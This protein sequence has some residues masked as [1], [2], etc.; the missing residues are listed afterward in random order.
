MNS[1]NIIKEG[2]V[3][4]ANIVK[5]TVIN[6]IF[7]IAQSDAPIDIDKILDE[8]KRWILSKIREQIIFNDEHCHIKRI[9]RGNEQKI[10]ADDLLNK[11]PQSKTSLITGPSKSE[12]SKLAALTTVIWAMSAESRF[13]LVLFISPLF[14]MDKIPLHK[15]VWGEFAGHIREQDSMKIYNKLLE[16]KD[17]ILF[18]IDGLGSSKLYSTL[19]R[20]SAMTQLYKS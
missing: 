18:I 9:L 14:K 6:P 4:G 17:K 3:Q 2:G 19:F 10:S 15:Q 7:N 16:M 20:I 5:S 13:D 1:N 11:I 8:Y 12:K